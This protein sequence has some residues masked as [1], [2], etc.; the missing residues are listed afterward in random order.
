MKQNFFNQFYL[1]NGLS[2]L[3]SLSNYNMREDLFKNLTE[4]N[5]SKN[6]SVVSNA[7]AIEDKDLL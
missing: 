2:K 3:R 1:L 6:D 7:Q 5:S 4:D